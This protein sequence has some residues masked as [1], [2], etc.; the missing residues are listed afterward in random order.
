MALDTE[1]HREVALKQIH[2]H[3]AD[4]PTSR[5]RFLVEAEITGGLEHPGIVPVYG[6]G[7]YGSGRPFYAM[8]F[9]RGDSLKEAVDHFHADVTLRDNPGRRV[10]ELQKLLRRFLDVCNAIQYAHSRGVLHRD[11]KPG[12]VVVGKHGETLV[13]DWGLAKPL[14]H[15]EPGDASD[16]PTLVPSSASG[17]AETLPGTAVGTPAYMSPEQAAGALDRLSVRSDVYSLGATLYYLLTGKPPFSG[18]DVGALLRAVQK[19]EFR[20]PRQ[21]NATVERAIEAVCLK[22]MALNPDDRYATPRELADDV[23]R[24]LADEP[25]SAWKE[26]RPTRL[27]RWGRR[28]K[29]IVA[30][31]AVLLVTALVALSIGSVLLQG[32]NREVEK[33]KNRANEQAKIA[34]REKERAEEQTVRVLNALKAIVFNISQ[35]DLPIGSEG[36]R[37]QREILKTT[38]EQLEK[39]VHDSDMT[40]YTSRATISVYIMLGD[41]AMILRERANALRYYK[42]AQKYAEALVKSDRASPEAQRDL[43]LAYNKLGDLSGELREFAGARDYYRQALGIAEVLPKGDHDKPKAQRDLAILYERLGDVSLK[44][45]DPVAAREYY[46]KASE[47]KA[48]TPPG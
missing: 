20:R 42:S 21:R 6:L 41:V 18:D 44:L 22:A 19:G 36:H 4:D 32:R 33:Q 14:G 37:L 5:H 31:V 29:P 16:E 3:H 7:T 17:T 13:V 12:N 9:I 24:W 46:R 15:C 23:E 43:F 48:T 26:R 1:L 25:V 27:A 11:I 10:L 30:G 2:D 35:I 28:H 47:T 34:R 8:R 45:G 40:K 38:A 39:L